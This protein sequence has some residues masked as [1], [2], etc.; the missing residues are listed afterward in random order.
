MFL[1]RRTEVEH[2]SVSRVEVNIVEEWDGQEKQ[3][4]Y[5]SVM[6]DNVLDQPVEIHCGA[7]NW[8][9]SYLYLTSD[10]GCRWRCKFI[11]NIWVGMKSD[12]LS[13]SRKQVKVEIRSM[14]DR[15]RCSSSSSCCWCLSKAQRTTDSIG[16]AWETVTVKV[17]LEL[18]YL[19]RQLLGG[20]EEL[21]S[22]YNSP[23]L[24]RLLGIACWKR[25]ENVAVYMPCVLLSLPASVFLSLSFLARAEWAGKYVLARA[26][27][28]SY[29]AVRILVVSRYF[30]ER[31]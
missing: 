24:L 31:A 19:M 4:K 27:A 10:R 12:D 2:N 26:V 29:N 3:D 11:K 23:G 25:R 14:I 30:C 15:L 7:I 9:K 16:R 8:R 22:G 5:P 18:R 28:F 1:W 6:H 13:K 21:L 20:L 17:A